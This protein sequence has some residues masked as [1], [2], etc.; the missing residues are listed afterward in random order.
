MSIEPETDLERRIMADPEWQEGA[1]WGKP[2][3]GHPEGSIAAHIEEV[4]ANI[5]RYALDHED[6]AR[7]RLIA[8]VHDTFKHEVNHL[9][10][11]GGRNDHAALARRFAERYIDDPG[12][13]EVV[14]LHDEAYRAWRKDD[15]ER[16]HRLIDRL[17]E[18][19]GLFRRFHR[20]D[21]E[22]GDK[23]DDDRIWFDRICEDRRAA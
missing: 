9:L 17:G 23:S 19:L 11:F 14:E 13:L 12:I 21:N 6:R 5:D 7:L 4:L 18:N 2:R 8:I 16:A 1:A 20:S 15:E 3:R 22:T 10:P